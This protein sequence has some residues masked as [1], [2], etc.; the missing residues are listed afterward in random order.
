MFVVSTGMV[1]PVGLTGAAACEAM[2][3][4]IAMLEELSYCDNQGEPIIGAVVPGLVPELSRKDRLLEMLVMALADCLGDDPSI[5]TL[6][7]PLLVGLAEENRPGGGASLADTV[8]AEMQTTLG[9]KFRPNRSGAIPKGHTSG[10]EALRIARE[11]LRNSD[12][13]GCLVCGV[14]SYVNAN[15]LLWLDQH[16]RLKTPANQHGLI[17]GEAAAAV[18]VQTGTVCWTGG[19]GKWL[20]IWQGGGTCSVGRAATR[21]GTDRGGAHGFGGSAMRVARNGLADLRRDGRA[22]RFQGTAAGR[23]SVDAHGPEGKPGTLAR[24]PIPSV[25]SGP[26]PASRN[27]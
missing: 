8:V 7:I 18:L 25:M 10:F 20:G 6:E 4:D 19:R 26:P 2:R 24:A 17:P 14:D 9:R 11:W 23:G 12:I 3:A 16:W 21:P 5:S 27:W 15:S 13:P 22:I 1:C